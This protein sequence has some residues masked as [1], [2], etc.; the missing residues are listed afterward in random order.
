MT[1]PELFPPDRGLGRMDYS[2]APAAVYYIAS[3]GDRWRVHDCVMHE[4]KL[5]RIGLPGAERA[6][7]RV[8]VAESGVRKLYRRLPREIWEATP[9]HLD[10]QLTTAEYLPMGPGF[11]AVERTAR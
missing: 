6:T 10:R 9:A 11:T 1:E 7:A 5:R 3:T 8:F 2:Q 4:G